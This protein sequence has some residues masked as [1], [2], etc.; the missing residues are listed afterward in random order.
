MITINV[1]KD[2]GRKD[3][4][5][6]PV[7]YCEGSCLSTDTKPTQWDNGSKLLE[8]EGLQAVDLVDRTAILFGYLNVAGEEVYLNPANI[9]HEIMTDFI[10]VTANA[11]YTMFWWGT[12]SGEY[13]HRLCWYDFVNAPHVTD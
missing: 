12:L 7:K 4:N 3:A 13:W 2:L 5:G 9:N 1:V 8:M 6:N 10:P 11:D